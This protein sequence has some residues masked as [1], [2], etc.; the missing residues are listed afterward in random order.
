[1]RPR[2]ERSSIARA[3]VCGVSALLVATGCT[4]TA[5]A[6]GQSGGESGGVGAPA[7]TTVLV[8]G[9]IAVLDP[10]NT[11]VQALGYRDGVII[12]VGTNDQVR[13][14]AGS[15]AQVI[16]LKGRTVIPG[17]IDGTLHGVRNSVDCFLRQVR[18]DTT[19]TRQE[20]LAAY[21][22]KGK[23]LPAGTWIFT[24]SGWNVSQLDKP[25]MFTRAE[26]DEAVPNDPVAIQ[27]VGFT[28]IQTN[29]K[30]LDATGF[31][32]GSTDPGVVKD[33]NGRPTGQLTGTAAAT[34]R[35][36]MGKQLRTI[37]IDQQV[38]CMKAF[39]RE[40]NRVG[41]TSWDDPAGNDQFDP[42]GR[43][44]ELLTGEHGY[45]AINQIHRDG[46]MTVRVVL[47][48]SCFTT[49]VPALDCVKQYTP[50]AVSLVGDDWLRIGGMGEEL[51]TNMSNG[52]YPMPDYQ[53]AV[54]YL[55]ENRWNLEHHAQSPAQQAEV[56]EAWERANAKASIKELGWRMLHPF[57]GAAYPT[58]DTLRRLKALNAGV[59]LTNS[60]SQGQLTQEHPP[61]RRAYESG[62]RMC[63]GT[64]ALNV[65]TYAPF[66]NLWYTISGKT[67]DPAIVGVQPDQRLTREQALRAA[68]ANCA[69]FIHLDNKVGTLEPGKYADLVVLTKDY[70]S[71]PVDEIRSLTSV[72]TITG[73]KVGW[74]SGDY[75][76]LAPKQ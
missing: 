3:L 66:N 43:Q 42:Q 4:A 11:V 48:F 73:G 28:G 9:K 26:L 19:T 69:W 23:E 34:L 61:F 49:G 27:G 56:V 38:A 15:N 46:Q 51:T 5:P 30:G 59:V 16:D 31:A 57:G 1:M 67:L 62:T 39:M 36:T 41:L 44:Q 6:P 74:A 50:T 64:D 76:S 63:L 55:A 13:Q 58:D 32:S 14:A 18:H 45:Q 22:A 60:N 70:F 37:S 65:S 12:A 52:L 2:A 20:A 10:G 68:T 47:H 24:W 54:D 7:S 40:A 29:S 17:L 53:L 21:A 75:A 35:A 33:G 25:G 8:N 71:I 72:L